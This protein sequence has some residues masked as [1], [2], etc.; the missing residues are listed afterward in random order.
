[1]TVVVSIASIPGDDDAGDAEWWRGNVV[2]LDR[3][4]PP[5]CHS[6]LGENRVGGGVDLI[7]V[8]GADELLEHGDVRVVCRVQSEAPRKGFE[9]AGVVGLG[10]LNHRRVRF[11]RDVDCRDRVFLRV[12]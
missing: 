7:E 5:A 1:M 12:G 11:Q 2:V 9:Q 8:G 4:E 3:L 6:F 10:P